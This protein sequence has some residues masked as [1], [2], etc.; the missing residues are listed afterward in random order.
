MDPEGKK[1]GDFGRKPAG[2]VGDNASNRG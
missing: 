1:T 2:G